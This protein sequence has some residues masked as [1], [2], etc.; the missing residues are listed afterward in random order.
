[1][2]F[3]LPGKRVIDKGVV[4]IIVEIR[5]QKGGGCQRQAL[6]FDAKREYMTKMASWTRGGGVKCASLTRVGCQRQAL[7]VDA[8]REFRGCSY[9]SGINNSGNNSKQCDFV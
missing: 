9:Y 7:V 6:V 4:S 8:K 3:F 1:M 5:H 2:A